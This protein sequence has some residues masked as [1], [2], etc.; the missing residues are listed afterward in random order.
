[1]VAFV[2]VGNGSGTS[3]SLTALAPSPAVVS[4]ISALVVSSNSV[5]R[6]LVII[7]TGE[8]DVYFGT[9]QA[10]ILGAGLVLSPFGTWVM[11]AY[12]FSTEAI[13]A[14]T[15]SNSTLS[16]QEYI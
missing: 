12:T 4:T 2:Q 14:I 15:S 13:Y 16:I 9:G 8:A 3:D 7:N 5:R 6:S 1:M 11:D 10:A